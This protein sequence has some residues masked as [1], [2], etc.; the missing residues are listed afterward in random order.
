MRRLRLFLS[1]PSGAAAVE[2]GLILAAIA[3]AVIVL[4]SLMGGKLG[5]ARNEVTRTHVARDPSD[6]GGAPDGG[7]FILRR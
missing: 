4:L 3:V 5:S 2:Y 7:R 6:D 1:D